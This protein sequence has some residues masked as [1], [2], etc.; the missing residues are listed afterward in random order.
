MTVSLE[1]AAEIQ[2]LP[3]PQ[4]LPDGEDMWLERQN[5]MIKVARCMDVYSKLRRRQHRAIHSHEYYYC[6]MNVVVSM[7]EN[8]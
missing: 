6:S 3:S 2:A 7:E 5:G 1:A 8:Y 4:V